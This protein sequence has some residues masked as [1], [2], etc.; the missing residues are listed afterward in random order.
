VASAAHRA[1]PGRCAEGAAEAFSADPERLARF[2]REAQVL[3]SLNHPNIAHVYGFEQADGVPALVMELVEGPTLADRIAQGPIPVDEALPI[4]KQ[5]AEALEAAH[6]QGIIHRDLK[7]ANIKLRPDGTVKVLDFGLAKA[8]DSAPPA[9]DASQSPTITSPAMMSRVGIILGTASYMSPEQARGKPVDKRSDIWAF[10][11]V[12]YEML[13]VKR[14]FTGDDVTA[15]LARIVERYPDWSALPASV[16]ARVR[17]LLRLCLEK[18]PKR[19]RQA[20][21]DIRVDLEQALVESVGAPPIEE[22]PER[23]A[24]HLW[25]PVVAASLV[26]A[27]IA[28]AAVWLAM[29]P[30]AQP[31]TRFTIAPIGAEQPSVSNIDRDLTLTPDGRYVVYRGSNGT[32]LYV[33]PVDGLEGTRLATGEIRGLF[34]S[35]DG[36]W[37]GFSDGLTA[38]K[39]VALTGGPVVTITPHDGGNSR[40]AVWLSDDTVIFAG[41]NPAIG[42]QRVSAGGGEV[43]VLTRPDRTR[44][45]IDHL[46]PEALPGGSEI[47]YTILT[48]DG[49]DASQIAVLDLATGTSNVVLRGGSHA[50]YVPTGHLLYGARGTLLAVPFDVAQSEVRGTPVPVLLRI[51]AHHERSFRSNVNTDSDRW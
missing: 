28:G 25:I 51:P 30:G 43:V 33:R 34:A 23:H 9:I 27:V 21:G 38:L 42:L 39:K 37:V 14:A 8:L 49:P 24:R 40:G 5:I 48:A 18:D 10:G 16:P 6:E 2:R 29:R 4:A 45:E 1:E 44:G 12:V 47:L 11:C 13:T 7:P 19:R 36:R 31:V 46:W 3:A 20:V 41:S 50:H 17:E 22:P 15:V 32:A 26:G 35:P